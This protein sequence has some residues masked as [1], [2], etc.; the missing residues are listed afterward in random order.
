M[1]LI[2]NEECFRDLSAV[3]KIENNKVK[4]IFYEYTQLRKDVTFIT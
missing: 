1:N 3:I 4:D 2:R